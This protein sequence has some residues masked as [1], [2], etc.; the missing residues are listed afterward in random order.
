MHKPLSE[1][2]SGPP[3]GCMEKTWQQ[4]AFVYPFAANA[5]AVAL[6]CTGFFNFL[7]SPK[8]ICM[9]AGV[10]G[11]SPSISQVLRTYRSSSNVVSRMTW[12]AAGLVVSSGMFQSV[13]LI[14]ELRRKGVFDGT[15]F[16]WFEFK[17]E[18]LFGDR[19]GRIAWYHFPPVTRHLHFNSIILQMMTICVFGIL[20][21][22]TSRVNPCGD[23]A[24]PQQFLENKWHQLPT[25]ALFFV[26]ALGA[27]L[28]LYRAYLRTSASTWTRRD[29]WGADAKDQS[30]VVNLLELFGFLCF[31]GFQYALHWLVPDNLCNAIADANTTL[32]TLT[33]TTGTKLAEYT[34][35]VH[36]A[37]EEEA[38]A[39]SYLIF[40]LFARVLFDM[41]ELFNGFTRI[42]TSIC[43]LS[44][45]FLLMLLVCACF[46]RVG[47]YL[48]TGWSQI[49]VTNSPDTASFCLDL[50]A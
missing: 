26:S 15:D 20:A 9:A 48:I 14:S 27:G 30:L 41:Q 32:A 33:E 37:F 4:F 38:W 39:L 16:E 25:G 44:W 10:L 7:S 31:L 8:P 49:P 1:N 5:A 35:L 13:G 22:P 28:S 2:C 29:L 21:L 19:H 43:G 42:G 11:P 34:D 46:M 45:T 12:V 18:A 24:T 23:A 6:V 40:G 3:R 50:P 36:D 47:A 17:F